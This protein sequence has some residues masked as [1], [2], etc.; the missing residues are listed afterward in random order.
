MSTLGSES[1]KVPTSPQPQSREKRNSVNCHCSELRCPVLV[2]IGIPHVGV[3]TTFRYQIHG[4][5]SASQYS[6]ISPYKQ[7][8]A[9]Y[10]QRGQRTLAPLSNLHYICCYHL[11]GDP[12]IPQP[13]Q[14]RRFT[15]SQASRNRSGLNSSYHSP[16]IPRSRG[17]RPHCAT[18]LPVPHQSFVGC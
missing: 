8:K 1:Y 15:I 7:I 14:L 3:Q 6:T 10:A 4:Y 9:A 12:A 17:H 18:S 11:T 5:Y 13:Q 2:N 16:D